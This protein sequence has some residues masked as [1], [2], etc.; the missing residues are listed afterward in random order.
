MREF[1]DGSWLESCK[2]GH[3]NAEKTLLCQQG[4]I[5]VQKNCERTRKLK[6]LKIFEVKKKT[7]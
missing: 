7:E 3:A 4:T 1:W 2:E 5:S 6:M